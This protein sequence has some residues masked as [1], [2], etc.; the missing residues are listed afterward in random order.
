MVAPVAAADAAAGQ[1]APPRAAGAA[2]V[3]ADGAGAR[4]RRRARGLDR[5]GDSSIADPVL[6]AP[7]RRHA[8]A[9]RCRSSRRLARTARRHASRGAG[10]AARGPR[11]VAGAAGRRDRRGPARARATPISLAA[12]SRRRSIRPRPTR[13]T[14]RPAASRSWT[15]RSSR[16]RSSAR[17]T[18]SAR[19]RS[20][21]ARRG[22]SPRS[23]STRVITPA[24][25][26][27]LLFTAMVEAG[28]ARSARRGIGRASTTP[29]GSTS[30]GT[31]AT[32]TTATG[33]TSTGTT[34]T[35]SSSSRCCSTSSMPS[36]GTSPNEPG[37]G[38]TRRGRPCGPR[39]SPGPD[40]MPRSRSASSRPTAAFPA[41][42]RSIAY[43]AG[44]FQLL[45]QIAL[46]RE[47]PEGV[48]PAR[49]EAALSAVL[50]P[51][52]RR[53]RDV[54][55]ERLAA[56][57]PGRTSAGRRRALHLDRQP[58]PVCHGVPAA[59][60]AAGR[61]VLGAAGTTVDCQAGVVRHPVP[62]R[63]CAVDRRV[64]RGLSRERRREAHR[65]GRGAVAP[66]A[67]P[68]I[69]FVLGLHKQACV[70]ILAPRCTKQ[71]FHAATACSI[72]SSCAWELDDRSPFGRRSPHHR[73]FRRL[74]PPR[75][76]AGRRLPR[77]H[78][79]PHQGRPHPAR[80]PRAQR[81]LALAER[82]LPAR[83]RPRLRQPDR[84]GPRLRRR[85]VHPGLRR[86]AGL[87]SP[88]L[89]RA[90]ARAAGVVRRPGR[91]VAPADAGARSE[92]VAGSPG[93]ARAPPRPT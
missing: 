93:P 51:H 85:A 28:L 88:A 1:T 41:I 77:N 74:A 7:R 64:R 25:S 49:S 72:C 67:S 65:R 20:G 62:H 44:A 32:A 8:E 6:D 35:A 82:H 38:R 15:P 12:P 86:T 50:D 13:S 68:W 36:A 81:R 30:S 26:N 71:R 10:P 40:A 61:S 69:S 58:L 52:A 89:A 5:A 4:R 76:R 63:P 34:T 73:G 45:A 80:G 33:P 92:P 46:R 48:A 60:P 31:S 37:A 9:S 14:S 90:T 59:R 16:T 27:W 17:R 84:A 22:S 56:D 79:D 19:P 47:L 91:A 66:A 23:T 42:G 2:D 57:R 75:A 11:P 70:T 53:P 78:R 87:A 18:R 24:F 54:R 55:R 39:C 21:D 29:C 83:L 43:R 3:A